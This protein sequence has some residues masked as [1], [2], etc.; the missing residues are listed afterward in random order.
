MELRLKVLFSFLLIINLMIFN[1]G[2]SQTFIDKL[3][4]FHEK[5]SGYDKKIYFENN[6]I[7]FELDNQIITKVNVNEKHFTLINGVDNKSFGIANYY[8]GQKEEESIVEIYL[9][10]DNFLVTFYKKLKFSYE[11]PLPKILVLS[12]NELVLFYP[13]IG[14]LKILGSNTEREFNLLKDSEKELFQER[15]GH[16]YFYNGNLIVFL[17][18]IKKLNDYVSRIYSINLN[19]FDFES[20]EIEMDYFY[21]VF[22]INS[23]IY[24]TLIDIEPYFQGA[25]FLL[26]F[27]K[28][29]FSENKVSLI[30]NLIIE[31]QIKNNP[32][33]LF[34][35]DCFY[36][37]SNNKIEKISLCF[38][39]EIIIDAISLKNKIYVLTRKNLKSN[40]YELNSN[41]KIVKQEVIESYL[42]NPEFNLHYQDNLIVTDRNKIILVKNIS[43]EK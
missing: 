28:N 21:K 37:L 39:G 27:N 23:Q 13:S 8:F 18:Q 19:S 14:V 5:T 24:F 33:I 34:S 10:D 31:G 9:I 36:K 43:E 17:S 40:I 29:Y 6:S 25:F 4:L 26:D 7:S 15:I 35:R 16:L 41:F 38:D 2:Q 1:T 11:E 32:T 3:I 42:S 12:S 20:F 30:D 22:Q